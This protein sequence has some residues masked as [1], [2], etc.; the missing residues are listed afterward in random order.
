MGE[1]LATGDADVVLD[2]TSLKDKCKPEELNEIVT[3]LGNRFTTVLL[4]AT[5]V[6]QSVNRLLR[7]LTN[8]AVQKSEPAGCATGV[9]FP[10]EGCR[11][12]REI[13]SYYYPRKQTQGMGLNICPITGVEV[14][15][16]LDQAPSFVHVRV[17]RANV[18]VWSTERVFDV[19]KPLAAEKEF[20]DA[21]EEYVPAIIFLRFAFGERCWHNPWIGAGIVIDDPLLKRH[22]GFIDFRRLL[23]S[24]RGHRYHVTLAFIPWNH[25]R[26]TRKQAQMFANYADCFSVCAH[27]CDHTKREFRS[28]DYENLLHR[29][30]L[31]TQR[32]DLHRSRV[33]LTNAPL[34]V[35]PQEEYS[36]QGIRAFADSR[37]FIALVCTACMP[38]DLS[39]PQI[40]GADLLL[41]AQDSFFG[42]PVFKRHYWS[43]MS[44]F[45]MALF[46]G[47]P[48]ILVEHH[49]FF[50]D[51]PV[52]A[53]RFASKLL[54]LRPDIKWEPLIETVIRTHLRR[55]TGQNSYAIRFFTDT[56]KLEHGSDSSSEYH[57][58]RRIPETTRVRRATV[59]GKE[60]AFT[61]KDH[62]VRLGIH[63]GGKQTFTIQVE[64]D[65]IR[66]TVTYSP[67]LKYNTSV[68]LRRGLSEFRDNVLARNELAL[69][70]SRFLAKALKQTAGN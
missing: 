68:A 4:L 8:G 54:R 27:G 3:L 9:A 43:D 60:T 6:D 17:G 29:N 67:G 26:T 57:L 44:A 49:E 70:A 5:A 52:G 31:A 30:F 23:E 56:F 7:G 64:I 50:K 48:A 18:F 53:E 47:K 38:R 65:P 25:W 16:T 19:S 36:L 58:S 35:C 55:D 40:R 41:P 22:Y 46:L 62:S 45:A 39:S 13:S 37:Q 15:M 32:M 24:A 42:F 34:M 12:S 28:D 2:V 11:F 66:P 10:K 59:N 14:I 61:H 20:E 1:A 33:G 63:A 21:I 51:G 69:R